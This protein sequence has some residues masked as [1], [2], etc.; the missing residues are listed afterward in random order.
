MADTL[1]ADPEQMDALLIVPE[2]ELI[3]VSNDDKFQVLSLSDLLQCIKR[4]KI[5][6]CENHQVLHTDLSNSC[7]GSIYSNFEQG[8]K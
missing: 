4:N 1:E 5:Y 6:L 2:A 7:L 8:I 3:A